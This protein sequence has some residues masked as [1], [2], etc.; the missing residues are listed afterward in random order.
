VAGAVK[1]RSEIFQSDA[2]PLYA[3]LRPTSESFEVVGRFGMNKGIIDPG[4]IPAFLAFLE[5]K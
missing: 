3:L 4:D 1:L 2:L 5:Q